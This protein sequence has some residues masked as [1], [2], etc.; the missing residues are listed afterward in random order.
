MCTQ[1]LHNIH[2][3]TDT[4]YPQFSK[5]AIPLLRTQFC[6]GVWLQS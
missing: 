2:P 6:S 1:Y 4:K 3:P 5:E